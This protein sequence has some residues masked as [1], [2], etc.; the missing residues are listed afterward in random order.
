[1]NRTHSERAVILAPQGRDAA[2]AEAM[3]QE[4]KLEAL[5]V[6]DV[7]SL[8]VTLRSGAG[9]AVV[10]EESLSGSDLRPL[11]EFLRDQEEWSDFPFIVLTSRGGG[12][13]RNPGAVRLLETL[14]NVTFL[15]RPFHPTSLISLARAARRARLRQYEARQR[16]E[17]IRDGQ[18]LMALALSAGRLGAWSVDLKTDELTASPDGKAHY[19]REPGDRFTLDDL[20]GAIHPDDLRRWRE[21]ITETIAGGGDLDVQYRAIWPDETMH[22]VQV[23]GRVERDAGG[24]PLR[25]VGV[26][27]DVTAR[28]S[29][30][31]RRAALLELGDRLRNMTDPGEMSYLTAEVLGRTLN[32]SRAGYGI[33]DPVA[34]TITIERD[35][36]A[37]GVQSLAG[38]LQFR[39]Y[40]SYIEDL[41]RGVTV[42]FADART[43]PR[44]RDTAAALEAID[45]RAVLNMPLVD[46]NNFVALLYLND[47]NAREWT[48]A[49]LAFVRDV[50]D[51]TQAAIER[52]VAEQALA[53]LNASLEQ[54][55]EERTRETEAAQEQLRQA[56]KMEA[57]GQLTG[58]LAHDFN[59]LLMGVSG[60]LELINRRVEQGRSSEIGRYLE[61][62]EAGVSRAAGLTHRLLAFSRR[63]TLDPKP[64]DIGEV[65]ANLEEFLQ[66]SV[67]PEIDVR[68]GKLDAL[69][70][71]LLDRNQ[72]ENA[73]LNLCINARD[74]MPG[75]GRIAI[76]AE[77]RA[78][79]EDA[80]RESDLEPGEYVRV[81]VTDTGTGMSPETIARAFDPFYTTKPIG[82]GTGLGLSMVYGFVRQ[83][84]GQVRIRS[85]EGKGTAIELQFPRHHGD[86]QQEEVPAA[87]HP[88]QAPSHGETVMVVD[89]EMVI[90]MLVV[91]QLE[92]LGY[93]TVEAGDGVSALAALDEGPPIDLLIT[94]VGLPNGL[95]G[96][97]LADAAR[98][99]Q[100]GLKIL[101][102]TGYAE[103]AVIGD[104]QLE[105]GMHLLTKPFEMDALADRV[106]ELISVEQ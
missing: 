43:D 1:L 42:A 83:S 65:I 19:G 2:V 60:A 28:R 96:R 102:I 29:A 25:M 8:A 13:E 77:N 86:R 40:G 71:T 18:E 74:A 34:E 88:E 45:A 11:V 95:N 78:L 105:P 52:R 103:N 44:T 32:V 17:D 70:P 15:E 82:E 54:L 66:R 14:G 51:R 67:G 49:E 24:K 84:G 92:D 104:S 48:D 31:N 7:A 69:W 89:D 38:V 10:T 37:P 97:Q 98:M 4:A 6:A 64:T 58:G 106:R 9:F 35:W 46:H 75:G 73:L 39:D 16:L 80:A 41:K 99:K 76:E 21:C 61:M 55:V 94:D 30:E 59:N 53:N 20:R 68:I 36:N 50:A 101:F 47:R 62:A 5:S 26:T 27:Q 87:P 72:F 90:R 23:N 85:A 56:Q 91:E 3:L 63:Q 57:V 33:I 81:T 22:W 12:I 93:T 100:P 79:D